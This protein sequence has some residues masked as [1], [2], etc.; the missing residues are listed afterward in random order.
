MVTEP[1]NEL[2]LEDESPSSSS[3]GDT[4]R[5]FAGLCWFHRKTFLG[6]VVLAGVGG[7]VYFLNAGK[8]VD[9]ANATKRLAN[10]EIPS[11]KIGANPKQQIESESQSPA[12]PA[13]S[14]VAQDQNNKGENGDAELKSES[15]KRT[16][17]S[18]VMKRGGKQELIEYSLQLMSKWRQNRPSAA[19]GSLMMSDR[20]RV[21]KK[22]ME[23]EL[24]ETERNYAIISY[25][26]SVS[27][28]DSLNVQ[29]RLGLEGTRDALVEVERLYCDHENAAIAGKANLALAMIPG[30]DF[31]V[32]NDE[33]QLQQ[34]LREVEARSDKL[35]GES[36]A[37]AQLVE[38]CLGILRSSQYR[39]EVREVVV[40]IQKQL[41]RAIGD[42]QPELC[43]NFTE[44]IFFGELDVLALVAQIPNDDTQTRARV[45]LLFD[46]L[47][48]APGVRVEIYLTAAKCIRTYIQLRKYNDASDLLGHLETAARLN[49]N[50]AD[51][52][53]VIEAIAILKSELA[54]ITTN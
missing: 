26:E 10:E 5:F 15:E 29:N 36:R 33:A 20:L 50:E 9:D 53:K 54:E 32:S 41:E 1:E 18:D 38:V 25:V 2:P 12:K 44:R 21:A 45:K 8:E 46:G 34:F 49:P 48:K 52:A 23:M 39:P 16:G 11:V 3:F 22:L 30:Y 4:L 14:M 43:R 37:A 35:F 31:L 51:K 24:T 13:I 6:I 28:L 17:V 7:W 19:T 42:E 47:K 40:K 27:T